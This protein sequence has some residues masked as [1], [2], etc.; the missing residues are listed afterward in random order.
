MLCSTWAPWPYDEL[1]DESVYRKILL[2]AWL[3]LGTSALKMRCP[4]S[5]PAVV[6]RV[7]NG[8]RFQINNSILS[9]RHIRA[10]PT[11]WKALTNTP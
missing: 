1:G 9:L 3:T 6:L 8:N 11:G 10:S 2:P 4:T 7:L 5:A